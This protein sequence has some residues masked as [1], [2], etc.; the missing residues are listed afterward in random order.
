MKSP[1]FGNKFSGF[2]CLLREKNSTSFSKERSKKLLPLLVLAFVTPAFAGEI[3]VSTWNLNWLTQ[4][5][6]VEADLPADVH[7]RAPEDFVR[8]AGY[9]RK[10]DADV[11]A[12]QEVDGAPA[13]R[14]IF[15]PAQYTILTIDEPVVQQVGIAVRKPL[16]IHRNPDLVGLDAEPGVK[17]RLRYGLDVTLVTGLRILVVHLK[18]G[19]QT[20]SLVTSHRAQ[21]ALLARQIPALSGWIADRKAEGGPFM[22]LG[23]FNRVF[24]KTEEFGTALAQAA[25][26]L[27]TTQGFENPCWDGAPFIDHIFLGGPARAWLVPGSLRVQIF[28]EVGDSWKEKLSDH[29]PVSIKLRLPS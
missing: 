18:T 24:D 9:A 8:L 25:P 16:Q 15:D 6:K 17:Y 7:T 1:A 4:R 27:R 20:D 29:C 2:W 21:C 13:A 19:C 10:L 28:Q 3:K 26:L 14:L 22:V 23:D 5:S 12:F 11:I